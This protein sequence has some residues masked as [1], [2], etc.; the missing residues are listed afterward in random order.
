MMDATSLRAGAV[1]STLKSLFFLSERYS[2]LFEKEK[3]KDVPAQPVAAIY[4]YI[5]TTWL[6]LFLLSLYNEKKKRENESTT[7]EKQ[8]FFLSEKKRGVPCSEWFCRSARFVGE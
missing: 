5:H 6:L 3:K 8:V 7:S 1:T 4:L 2:I